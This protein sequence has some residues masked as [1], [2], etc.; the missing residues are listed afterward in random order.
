MMKD[1]RES[2]HP[3][4]SGGDGMGRI[5]D[6]NCRDNGIAAC[7]AASAAL[8]LRFQNGNQLVFLGVG[9]AV[10]K[11]M[12]DKG[13][14]AEEHL[15]AQP[16]KGFGAGCSTLNI[17]RVTSQERTALRKRGYSGKRLWFHLFFCRFDLSKGQCLWGSGRKA[18]KPSRACEV[19]SRGF[20]RLSTMRV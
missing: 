19:R 12:A 15:N 4:P 16:R 3:C 8:R 18:S 7:R 20:R 6:W 2:T 17:Q 1:E 5:G 14:K 10:A 9:S 13:G 11:A